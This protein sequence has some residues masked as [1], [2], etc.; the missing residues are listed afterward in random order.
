MLI[1]ASSGKAARNRIY[2]S[3][4]CC[5]IQSFSAPMFSLVPFRRRGIEKEDEGFKMIKSLGAAGTEGATSHPL[6]S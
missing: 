2:K 5:W 3:A 4:R 6:A 1:G